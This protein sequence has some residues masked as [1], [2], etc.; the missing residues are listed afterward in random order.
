MRRISAAAFVY[1][2][3]ATNTLAA[4]DMKMAC[5]AAIRS[6]LLTPESFKLLDA[7]EYSRAISRDDY[8]QELGESA[9]SPNVQKAR[10]AIFDAR[11]GKAEYKRMTMRFEATDARSQPVKAL[12]ICEA[13][14]V[15]DDQPDA[16]GVKLDGKDRTDWLIS[17]AK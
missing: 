3:M 6:R 8:A 7:E 14:L 16:E 13:T 2:A 15:G 1:V 12:T 4:N 5:E 11:G 10:L 9:D 17:G